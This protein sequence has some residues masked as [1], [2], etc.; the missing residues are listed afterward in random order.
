MM[1]QGMTVDFVAI[2]KHGLVSYI[3]HNA[4]G[5][6]ADYNSTSGIYSSL[7]HSAQNIQI[8]RMPPFSPFL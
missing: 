4:I 8:F 6:P 1:E 3:T 5:L 2:L 7:P